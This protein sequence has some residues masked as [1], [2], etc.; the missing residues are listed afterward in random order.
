MPQ[1]AETSR[2]SRLKRL[3][4]Y[5]NRAEEIRALARGV[6]HSTQKSLLDVAAAYDILAAELTAEMETA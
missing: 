3:V 4:F 5:R 1:R 6:T 2:D